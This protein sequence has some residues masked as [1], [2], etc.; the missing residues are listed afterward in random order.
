MFTSLTA[1]LTDL[2]TPRRTFLSSRRRRIIFLSVLL[3][4]AVGIASARLAS[5][6]LSTLGVDD[7]VEY[8]G[9]GRLTLTGGNPYSPDELLVLQREVGWDEAMPLMMWN[10]PPALTLVMPFGLLP[11]S[12]ARVLWFLISFALV[13]VAA[14]A[15]WLMYGGAPKKR[16]WSPILAIT[17]TP[18]IFVL[19]IGQIGVWVMVGI[20]GFLFFARQE[21]WGAAGALLALTLIKPHVAYLVWGAVALWWLQKPRWWLVFGVVTTVIV[22]WSMA[23]LVNLQVTAQYWEAVVNAPP[24][25]WRTMTWGIVL[26]LWLGLEKEWLQFI[27]SLF[28]AAWLLYWWAKRRDQWNWLEETPRLLLVSASTMA[29]GWLFD[30]VVLLPIVIQMGVWSSQERDRLVRFGVWVIYALLQLSVLWVN[31]LRFDAIYFVWFAP[32]LL[33]LYLYYRGRRETATI[34]QRGSTLVGEL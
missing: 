32:A 9:A 2:R 11:Y 15:L 3:L 34:P 16:I 22:G 21:R 30:L 13:V 31:S 17:F 24:L 1:I 5:V 10:P 23:A 7:F 18:T 26:R 20:V 8:W 33:L 14:D 25:Y 4:I 28:G 27:P 6:N 12:L 29:F 19:L